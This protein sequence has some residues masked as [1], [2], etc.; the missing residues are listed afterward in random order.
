MHRE[1]Q[2]CV[3]YH[4]PPAPG[5]SADDIDITEEAPYVA[6]TSVR[7]GKHCSQTLVS[8]DAQD[9]L[10]SKVVCGADH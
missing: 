1:L 7:R 10:V 9:W 6:A 8:D 2:S 3:F 4:E 5:A